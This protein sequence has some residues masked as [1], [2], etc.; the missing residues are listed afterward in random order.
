MEEDR[1]TLNLQK[2]DDGL[3]ECRGRLQGDY[4]IYI[5]DST[6]LAEKIVQ[7]AHNATLHGGVGLT[8]A[9]IIEQ[10]WIPRLRRLVKRT[11]KKCYGCKRFQAVALAKPPPGLLPQE[12]TKA[13]GVFE[14]VGVDF[15]GPTKYRKSSRQEG[16]AYSLLGFVRLQL[17]KSPVPRRFAEPG[18]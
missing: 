8:M 3:L 10:F 4:P 12:R 5:P 7:Q 2:N 18:D 14:L 17:D 15:A 9:R 6:I 1:L 16:K 11:V 13:A